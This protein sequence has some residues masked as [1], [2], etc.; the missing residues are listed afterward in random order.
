LAKISA[1]IV[2]QRPRCRDVHS[3]SNALFRR[4]RS[5]RLTSP[6]STDTAHS[7]CGSL[8]VR[9]FDDRTYRVAFSVLNRATRR[10][11][12]KVLVPALRTL[13]SCQLAARAEPNLSGKQG[14]TLTRSHAP[15]PRTVLSG[16][17][18]CFTLQG[19]VVLI[20][21]EVQSNTV[22]SCPR[23][24][25]EACRQK[26]PHSVVRHFY[27]YPTRLPSRRMISR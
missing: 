3:L 6:V 8:M 14:E 16:H 23:P 4:C 2:S 5:F 7:L 26:N 15:A 18:A 19:L 9:W 17:P 22:R 24:K 10:S 20:V 13:L 25:L 12:D 1:K 11:S 21:V 27:T